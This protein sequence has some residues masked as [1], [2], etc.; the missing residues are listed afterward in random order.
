MSVP[1]SIPLPNSG[2]KSRPASPERLQP[3]LAG[4]ESRAP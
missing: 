4:A 2:H 3:E 1:S